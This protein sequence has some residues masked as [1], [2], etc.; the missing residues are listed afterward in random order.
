MKNYQN[1]LSVDCHRQLQAGQIILVL[2]LVMTIALT[3]SL[4]VIT[5]TI[6]SIRTSTE[7]ENSQR[8]FS[9]A[10]AGIE[11]ALQEST[12]SSGRF[13]QNTSYQ[14]SIAPLSGVDILLNNGTFILKDDAADLWL[15][16]YPGY[17][18]PWTG[19]LTIYWGTTAD[20]CDPDEGVNTM[21]ALEIVIISGSKSAPSVAHY[22]VDPCSA[23]Q[24]FNNFEFISPGGGTVGNKTFAYKKTIDTITNGL[25][26]R[27]MPLYSSATVGVR[28]CDRNNVCTS[29]PS[30]GTLVTSVGTSDTTQRKIVGL[31]ENPKLPIQ[32]F[33]YVIFSPK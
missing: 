5:H 25:L 9:A 13:G 15:S 4:S 2:L 1:G 26:M 19:P 3:I 32:I 27:I 29:L 7:E 14:T 30:Q 28:G 22:P 24:A 21:A 6:T 23:R 16:T 18:N 17:T 11:K 20:V 10:E 31:K 33:P 8:A 12:G